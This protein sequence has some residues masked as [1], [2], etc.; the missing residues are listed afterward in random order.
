MMY[1]LVPFT[2]WSWMTNVLLSSKQIAKFIGVSSGFLLSEILG[3]S[4]L[5]ARML[6]PKHKKNGNFQDT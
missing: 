4:K 5:L 2:V 3:I 1:E 6:T